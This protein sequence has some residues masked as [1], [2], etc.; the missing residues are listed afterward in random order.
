MQ[1]VTTNGTL[2]FNQTLLIL[3]QK[4]D[5]QDFAKKQTVIEN[6]KISLSESELSVSNLDSEEA[7]DVLSHKNTKI[8][9]QK[10]IPKLQVS[11]SFRMPKSSLKVGIFES[12]RNL[13]IDQN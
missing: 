5:A 1:G 6:D 12:A 13:V 11:K 3:G 8:I 4:K 7:D 10:K 9:A 2:S